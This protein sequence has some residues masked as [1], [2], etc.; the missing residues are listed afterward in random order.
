M[1]SIKKKVTTNILDRPITPIYEFE[2]A[3]D[4]AALTVEEYELIE[5]IRYTS[6]FTQPS[7]VKDLKR[8]SKPPLLSV[9]CQISRKI[10]A[11]MPDHFNKVIDWSIE[12]S[13][14]NTKWDGHLICAEALNIDKIPLSPSSGTSLFDVLV[15]HKELFIGFD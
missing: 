6:V 7:L 3:L 12:I 1:K 5:Y 2:R 4:K 15:V 9:I 10:G 11:E 13:D 14:H 8:P